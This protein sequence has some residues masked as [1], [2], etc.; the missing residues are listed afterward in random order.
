MENYNQIL[1]NRARELIDIIREGKP[2]PIEHKNMLSIT[3]F[4]QT[5]EIILPKDEDETGKKHLYFNYEEYKDYIPYMKNILSTVKNGFDK[6]NDTTTI[7]IINGPEND[8]TL[9][10]SLLLISRIRDSIRHGHYIIDDDKNKVIINENEQNSYSLNCKI[11]LAYLDLLSTCGSSIISTANS[12]D[13]YDESVVPIS[14]QER[15]EITDNQAWRLLYEIGKRVNPTAGTN[16][17]ELY[18]SAAIYNYMFISLS[19]RPKNTQIINFEYYPF[20]RNVIMFDYYGKSKL[21]RYLEGFI[22]EN[23]KEIIRNYQEVLSFDAVDKPYFEKMIFKKLEYFCKVVPGYLKNRNQMCLESLSN[24]ISHTQMNF[25]PEGYIVLQD[26]KKHAD[27]SEDTSNFIMITKPDSLINLLD[28]IK[29]GKVDENSITINDVFDELSSVFSSIKINYRIQEI[30]KNED[31]TPA[32]LDFLNKNLEI[33]N[34]LLQGIDIDMLKQ[35]FKDLYELLYG[36]NFNIGL[37]TI[38]E[39][40]GLDP[41]QRNE[42]SIE[43]ISSLSI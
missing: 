40:E 18:L 2:I 23:Y 34:H 9:I 26:T 38:S 5:K 4:V 28:T 43:N 8:P 37:K 15:K 19:S 32:E 16:L 7:H 27:T 14:E 6:S 21:K 11:P 3:T 36:E 42:A 31:L 29:E 24:A 10:D 30:A 22:K 25:S 20:N 39:L 41:K 1:I 13:L 17:D 12:M 35:R 33:F